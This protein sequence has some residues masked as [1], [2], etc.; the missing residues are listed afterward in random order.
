M[1]QPEPRCRHVINP[2]VGHPTA[3]PPPGPIGTDGPQPACTA[4]GTGTGTGKDALLVW[5][6]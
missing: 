2:G 1:G 5:L 3:K 6:G 4:L